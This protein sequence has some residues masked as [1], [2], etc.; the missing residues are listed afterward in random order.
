M[1]A[2][3]SDILSDLFRGVAAIQARF[4]TISPDDQY[5]PVVV[6]E[7]LLRGRL[8]TIR[9]AQSPQGKLSL[10]IAYTFFE[11]TLKGIHRF[12]LLSYT[13]VADSHFRLFRAAKL[14][15]GTQDLRIAAIAVAHDAQLVTRNRR[16]YEQIPGLKL[17]VWA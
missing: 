13:S 17:D 7:E 4:A 14:R 16:D 15:V 10:P 11:A 9:R 3:D 12:Q 1:I 8:E 6:A 5:V 2:F